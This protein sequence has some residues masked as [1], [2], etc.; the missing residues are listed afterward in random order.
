LR[1]ETQLER[2]VYNGRGTA[3]VVLADVRGGDRS[4]S[5]YTIQGATAVFGGR[6]VQWVPTRYPNGPVALF[7]LRLLA[8]ENRSIHSLAP[9]DVQTSTQVPAGI[10]ET[11]FQRRSVPQ[12]RVDLSGPMSQFL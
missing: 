8:P 9:A 10:R 12:L 1:R 2:Q 5:D 4:E 3:S 6:F 11:I 7:Q